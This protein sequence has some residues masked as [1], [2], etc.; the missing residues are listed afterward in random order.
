MSYSQAGPM[1]AAAL[2]HQAGV[3]MW[4]AIFSGV[5]WNLGSCQAV[6]GIP[7]VP[8]AANMSLTAVLPFLGSGHAASR[9]SR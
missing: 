8:V 9:R 1:S 4:K 5:T 3:H 7:P 6:P 2:P